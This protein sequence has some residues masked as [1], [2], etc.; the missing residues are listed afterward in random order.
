MDRDEIIATLA[1]VAT[2][3]EGLA[4]SD[5]RQDGEIK[6]LSRILWT[7][8]GALVVANYHELAGL[9]VSLYNG[10]IH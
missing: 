3:V 2:V 10:A 6:A 8:T 1:K 4:E 9:A 7:M 5:K